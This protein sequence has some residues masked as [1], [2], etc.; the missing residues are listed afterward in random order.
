[1]SQDAIKDLIN[2]A[3]KKFGSGSLMFGNDAIKNVPIIC[4]TGSHKL[5][6]ALGCGGIPQGRI[7]EYF[8]Q[9]SGGKTSLSLLT[10]AEAQRKYPDKVVAFIDLENSFDRQWATNLGVDCDKLLFSQPDS[11]SETFELIQMMLNSD[12]VC[13]I[14]VDSVGG[15]LTQA[16][17]EAEY[18]QAQMAQLARLMSQ[19]LPKINNI[20]KNK[21]CTILFI[22][23]VRD[24]VGGYGSPEVTQGGKA[25]GFYS[26]IRADVRRKEV[27]GE[28]ENPEGFITKIKIAKN[29]VGPP[30]RVIETEFFI[31]TNGKFGIDHTNEIVD[32]AIVNGI[33]DKASAWYKYNGEKFQGRENL[34]TYIKENENIYNEIYSQ[35]SKT[36]LTRDVPVEGSLADITAKLE[37][38]YQEK[39]T[40]KK[41]RNKKE[42]IPEEKQPEE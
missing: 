19:S 23:Q 12:Q 10:M 1:M 25:L 40:K 21:F 24:R 6:M 11:G 38:E 31:G 30:F 41:T 17:I 14:V 34:L 37:A 29:K 36:V 22:N 33:I 16:Q 5:D 9:A 15:L 35:I 20:L 32:L 3:D 39:E 27:I 7:I 26:S 8:G 2:Q 4:S 28:K 42:E 13:F 18:D